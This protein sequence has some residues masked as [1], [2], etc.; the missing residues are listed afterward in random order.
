MDLLRTRSCG[1]HQA[2]NR[3]DPLTGVKSAERRKMAPGPWEVGRSW[4]ALKAVFR[5][6]Q[7]SLCSSCCLVAQSCP[8]FCNPMDCSPPGSSAHA[9]SQARVLEWVAVPFSRRSFQLRDRT[10]VT[11]IAGRFFTAEPPGND[12][13]ISVAHPWVSRGLCLSQSPRDPHWLKHHPWDNLAMVKEVEKSPPALKCFF[14]TVKDFS[15]AVSLAKQV[16]K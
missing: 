7:R 16:R 9:T 11:C 3:D 15:S 8:T 6:G 4:R 2:L 13:Q 5:Y 1:Q 14:P 10:Q 12:S